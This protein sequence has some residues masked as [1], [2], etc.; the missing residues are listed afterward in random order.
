MARFIN[1]TVLTAIAA[2]MA[3]GLLAPLVWPAAAAAARPAAKRMMKTGLAA[4]ERSREL[5][6][7]WSETASDLVAEVEAERA[8][9][10]RARTTASG[11]GGDAES[12]V[13]IDS[14]QH[15]RGEP[16]RHA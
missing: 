1:Q 4:F 7:E 3:G 11:G 8:E 14:G 16:K 10:L 9:E 5:A 6:A 2:G 13:R 12:V 15:P